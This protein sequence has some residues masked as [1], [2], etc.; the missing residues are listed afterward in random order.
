VRDKDNSAKSCRRAWVML[1]VEK[2][3]Q[4]WKRMSLECPVK[5]HNSMD[6]HED[7]ITRMNNTHE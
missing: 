3:P 5:T 4:Q 6:E 7:G 1:A 2:E